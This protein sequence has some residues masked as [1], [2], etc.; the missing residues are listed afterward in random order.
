[1]LKAWRER[2]NYTQVEAAKQ[3]RLSIHTLRNWEVARTKPQG[4]AYTLL[5]EII[6]KK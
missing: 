6:L 5:T 3:L 1:M 4:I 2:N